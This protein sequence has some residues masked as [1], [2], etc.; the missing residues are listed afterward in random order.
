VENLFQ[1]IMKKNLP[2]N[3]IPLS[4]GS[5]FM[6]CLMQNY[7][8]KLFILRKIEIFFILIIIFKLQVMSV[9]AQTSS[10]VSGKVLDENNEGMPG[11]SIQLKD[12][13]GVGTVTDIDGNYQ[14]R[15][16]E[17]K[18]KSVL[19]FSYLGYISQEIEVGN[20]NN[21]EIKLSPDVKAL[22][23]VVVI[24]YGTQNIKDRTGAVSQ[25]SSKDLQ[26]GVVQDPIQGLT[27]RVAGVNVMKR[28]GDPNAGFGVIIRGMAG[29]QAGTSPLF[30]V[31]GVIGVDPTTIAPDDI[32]SFTVLKDASAA[33][34]YGSRAANGVII[35]TTKRGKFSQEPEISVNSFYS[36]DRRE[37]SLALF[38]AEDLRK[39]ARNRE[40]LNDLDDRGYN[41]DW[42]EEIFRQG[43]TQ[44][45]T[46]AVAGGT[47]NTTYRGSFNFQ[48][49]KGVLRGTDK[50]RAIARLNTT[51]KGLNDRL[52][53]DM[54]IASTLENNNYRDYG[55]TGENSILF[56]AY[57]RNPT[58]PVYEEG[59]NFG[60]Y[61]EIDD[62]DNSNPM[63]LINEIKNQREAKRLLFNIKTDY[64]LIDGL[65]YS[66][67][68]SYTNDDY[69]SWFFRPSYLKTE[70]NGGFG[71]RSY[72][73]FNRLLFEHTLNYKTKFRDKHSFEALGGYTWQQD[74]GN[75]FFAQGQEF[76]SNS[77]GADNLGYANLVNPRDIGSFRDQ[78]RLISFIGRTIYN[79][80][81]K[82]FL[83]ATMRRDGS[84]RFGANH[85]WGLFPS[86]SAAWDI[87]RENFGLPTQISQLKLRIGYGMTGNQEIGNYNSITRFDVLNRSIDLSSPDGREALR[88]GP[89]NNPNPN[90][91]WEEN[92]EINVGLDFGI[93]NDRITGSFEYY[94]KITSDVLA[95][96]EVPVPPNLVG[97]TFANVGKISNEG[98]EIGI[99]GQVI[100]KK[101]FSW[102][103]I[104]T[105]ARNR[106]KVITLS[107]DLYTM[108]VLQR[109]HIGGMGLSNIWT[110]VVEPG[111]PFGTFKGW[112][113]AGV[114]EK[115]ESLF[116]TADGG[117]TTEQRD[118]DR[119]Y[120]GNAQPSFVAGWTNNFNYKNWDL[121]FSMRT[122]VGHKILNMTRMILGNPALPPFRN[123]LQA[124]ILDLE[125]ERFTDAPKY[126][127]RYIE[128]GSFLR[129]DFIS[130]GYNMPVANVKWLKTC[131][132]Y[133]S[134]NNLFLLT[135]YSGLD[136]EVNYQGYSGVGIDSFDV[137]PKTRTLTLGVNITL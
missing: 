52:K 80:N 99:N 54:N 87:S 78:A 98:F 126:S 19:V 4:R 135:R 38:S 46:I 105:F 34:I 95:S 82:Y 17:G 93:F 5:S 48:D 81:S 62:F 97:Q 41:T 122:M 88:I 119:F 49:F 94:R 113:Y 72:G 103:T 22:D 115:G 69:Q 86:A 96:Y 114:N 109:G 27:G 60:G 79:Y 42:Q 24:G 2:I 3:I 131:R 67:N 66:L 108:D 23:E 129:L 132:I 36:F 89:V 76:I 101:D 44:N 47:T 7:F 102:N 26:K 11:V 133:I 85:K 107:N 130:L 14:I 40:I 6:N 37:R 136:P 9:F 125:E 71:R 117:L 91:K 110:Q 43:I 100:R 25:V 1:F 116:Y 28:G 128:D 35:I 111:M 118:E 90:L 83:T 106:Q 39:Y 59:N 50:Q 123:G 73:T 124:D 112:K 92:R 18:Q 31:D 8:Q 29:F 32:E 68:S 77:V 137:Y 75:S 16:P 127:D 104:F 53:I 15:L 13:P 21:I 134:S 63:A 45:H 20:R 61:F 51:T 55:G 30:V 120:L 84:S 58:Y 56:Q 12:T 74:N 57:T 121:S 10:I 64:E 70:R 33:A 65:T